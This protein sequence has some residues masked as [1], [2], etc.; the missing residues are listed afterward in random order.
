MQKSKVIR[1]S[2]IRNSSLRRVVGVE[3]RVRGVR[4]AIFFYSILLSFSTQ[5]IISAHN[6]QTHNQSPSYNMQAHNQQTYLPS[7]PPLSPSHFSPQQTPSSQDYAQA[8]HQPQFCYPY[9]YYM[10]IPSTPPMSPFIIH[11]TIA[12]NPTS[13]TG[14]SVEVSAQAAPQVY[15]DAVQAT[16]QA[17]KFELAQTQ[18]VTQGQQM[19]MSAFDFAALNQSTES[20]LSAHKWK[21]FFGI[22]LAGYLSVCKKL[23]EE[24]LFIQNEHTWANWQPRFEDK[25][26][27]TNLLQDIQL[28]YLDP[29]DPQNHLTPLI[30]FYQHIESEEKRLAL[31][32]TWAAWIKKFRLTYFFPLKEYTIEYAQICK[33][34]VLAL[35]T[36]FRKWAATC[37]FLSTSKE[38]MVSQEAMVLT[39][40]DVS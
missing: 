25:S 31:F 18:L 30:N 36:V 11:N 15:Q 21:I 9:Q 3:R 14:Q 5:Y 34:R 6:P 26:L 35:Q 38:A 17:Q 33:K 19:Q 13:S 10:H 24:N 22:L 2:V 37:N 16:D 7:A 23:A 4:M 12:A 1:S 32:L 27:E 39:E 28:R 8:Q 40:S 20:F 29:L